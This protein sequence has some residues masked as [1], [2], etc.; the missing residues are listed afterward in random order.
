MSHSQRKKD[1]SKLEIWIGLKRNKFWIQISIFTDN[2][3]ALLPSRICKNDSNIDL[4][5]RL[6]SW[7]LQ[8][9]FVNFYWFFNQ[10]VKWKQTFLYCENE[11]S[12]VFSQIFCKKKLIFCHIFCQKKSLFSQIFLKKSWKNWTKI[13]TRLS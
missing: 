9:T 2:F 8:K 13:S 4:F 6:F 10:N 1:F 3:L 5:F 7:I 11:I 12:K